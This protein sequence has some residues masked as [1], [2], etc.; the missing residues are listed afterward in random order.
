M[1]DEWLGVYQRESEDI[2]QLSEGLDGRKFVLFLS[3]GIS[4][5]LSQASIKTGRRLLCVILFIS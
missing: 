3:E 4:D 2:M 5:E 1:V